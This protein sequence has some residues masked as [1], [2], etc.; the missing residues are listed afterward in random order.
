MGG[1][2]KAI[3]GGYVKKEILNSAYR[4]Q[5]EIEAKRR[6]IVG[7]NAYQ[8]SSPSKRKVQVLPERIQKDRV[9]ALR[10]AKLTRD[11]ESVREKLERLKSAA[12]R[13][14]NLLPTISDAVKTMCTVGEISDAL[15]DVHGVYRARQVI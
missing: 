14:E 15:R 11:A 2:L 5:M 1:M 7:V 10:A 13:G 9:R 8:P 12:Q 3:E 4:K 6:I